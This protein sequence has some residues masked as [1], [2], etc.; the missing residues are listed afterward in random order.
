LGTP[1]SPFLGASF[2]FEG[3]HRVEFLG[4]HK[5]S[6]DPAT[7]V[8][9]DIKNYY[10][11]CWRLLPDP[12]KPIETRHLYVHNFPVTTMDRQIYKI[13]AFNNVAAKSIEA[14][15]KAYLGLMRK[16]YCA[17]KSNVHKPSG[18]LAGTSSSKITPVSLDD[19]DEGMGTSSK[20]KKPQAQQRDSRQSVTSERSELDEDE[21]FSFLDDVV[22]ST[23]TKITKARQIV[24]LGSSS[25]TH[26]ATSDSRFPMVKPSARKQ[27]VLELEDDD[28]LLRGQ[29]P[30][31]KYA[32]VAEE[33]P[34]F[35]KY[36]PQQ[37][38]GVKP[39]PAFR[40]KLQRGGLKPTPPSQDYHDFW[41]KMFPLNPPKPFV[42]EQFDR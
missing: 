24:D 6:P 41:V 28:E 15:L 21:D 19:I 31:S 40:F 9:S 22:E 12:D 39:Q 11:A 42:Q 10:V 27:Q 1:T 32:Q 18:S 14:F 34:K 37:Y 23:M 30:K 13:A 16:F 26:S 36:A 3:E 17:V 7:D 25:P 33:T 2:I 20:K 29:A 5:S 38:S 35:S 8:K 4:I